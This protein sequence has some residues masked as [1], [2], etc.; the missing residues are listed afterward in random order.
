MVL[1]DDGVFH[2]ELEMTT[3]SVDGPKGRSWWHGVNRQIIVRVP[4]NTDYFVFIFPAEPW[5][6]LG[7]NFKISIDKS[8]K[9]VLT[10]SLG[11]FAGTN[12]EN[13]VPSEAKTPRKCS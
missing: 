9:T 3:T 8:T 4:K 1:P 13:Q 12:L 10:I 11:N 5:P 6:S 7:G 2:W